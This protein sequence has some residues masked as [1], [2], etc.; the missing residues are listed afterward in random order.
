MLTCQMPSHVS[1]HGKRLS[2][3][4]ETNREVPRVE[5][6]LASGSKC[7]DVGPIA[8]FCLFWGIVGLSHRSSGLQPSTLNP[9]PNSIRNPLPVLGYGIG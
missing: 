4:L 2:R 9:E 3:R 5:K 1:K 7:A 8:Y 6:A